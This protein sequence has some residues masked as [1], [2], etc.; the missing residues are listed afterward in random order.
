[1]T[2]D[3]QEK[4]FTVPNTHGIVLVKVFA[5]ETKLFRGPPEVFVRFN[6]Y[7]R[8]ELDGFEGR[9]VIWIDGGASCEDQV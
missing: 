5:V 4:L 8:A 9:V 2:T 7:G 6:E 1:M 3:G